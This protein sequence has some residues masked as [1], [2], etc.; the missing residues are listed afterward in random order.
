MLLEN[1]I[2]LD[3]ALENGNSDG[4]FNK[5]DGGSAA[6]TACVR[7]AGAIRQIPDDYFSGLAD[8]CLHLPQNIILFSRKQAFDLGHGTAHHRFLLIFCLHGDGTML[9][10]DHVANLTA[11]SVLL[12]PPHH[13]HFFA[14]FAQRKLLWLIMS[15][16][17]DDG[18]DL[19]VMGGQVRKITPLQVIG[20]QQLT[21]HYV[22]LHRSQQAHPTISLLAALLLA[23][24]QRTPTPIRGIQNTAPNGSHLL[25]QKV[26]SYVNAHA[27]EAI[28]IGAVARAVGLSDSHLRTSFHNIA[29]I[30]LGAYLRRMRLHRARTMMLA[31]NLRLTEVAARCGYDSIYAFSRAFH[32][33]MG[34]SP[35]T[36]RMRYLSSAKGSPSR[37]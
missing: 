35:S 1:N 24:F 10:D 33:E 20:L 12:V 22:A 37:R 36:Y 5:S 32:H 30:S 17:L 9:V 8:P 7:A 4:M 19:H 31:T 2:R 26:A 28:R 3:H 15:F 21:E 14:R 13:F 18:A 25:L 23:E 11:G 27:T 34:V 16:E 6:W 29:G